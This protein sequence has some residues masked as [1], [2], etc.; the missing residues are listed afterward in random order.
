[1]TEWM[2]KYTP[3]WISRGGS[4]HE[5]YMEE[6]E[7]VDV[8]EARALGSD[9]LPSS[10]TTSQNEVATQD[11]QHTTTREAHRDVYHR[12]KSSEEG[13]IDAP[14]WKHHGTQE[15][16]VSCRSQGAQGVPHRDMSS[17]PKSSWEAVGSFDAPSW[18]YTG[19]Q[20]G[21]T[22]WGSWRIQWSPKIVPPYLTVRF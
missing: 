9:T 8:G 17:L 19:T 14:S 11:F 7:K 21:S 15:D 3:I 16:D 12:T 13:T 2:C 22:S 18:K 4:L 20:Q 1:M 6:K 5:A 10:P